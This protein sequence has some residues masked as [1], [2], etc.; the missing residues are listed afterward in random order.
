MIRKISLLL[1]IFI[2]SLK[3]FAQYTFV[4][5]GTCGVPA[6]ACTNVCA[7][8]V[9]KI[10]NIKSSTA[11]YS[12]VLFSSSTST[13]FLPYSSVNL[14]G[15]STSITT[16]D[17]YTS[18]VTLPFRF[19]FYDDASSPYNK[20]V[21]SSNGIISFDITNAGLFSHYQMLKDTAGNFRTA[22]PGTGV[23]PMDL[24]DSLY[25][26]S[27]IMGPYH[28]LDMGVTTSANRKIKYDVV[29]VAPYRKFVLSFYQ[30]PLF[31]CNP[32][33]QN[34]HQIVLYEGTGIIEVFVYSNQYCTGATAWNDGRTMI[35]LQNYRRNKA[36]MPA[37]RKASSPQWGTAGMNETWRFVPSSGVPL[38]DSVSLYDT[39]GHFV[40]VGDTVD[41]GNGTYDVNF[42][43]I[44]PNLTGVTRFIIKTK[45]RDILNPGQ[46]IYGID[47]LRV[48]LDSGVMPSRPK[49]AATD[50]ILTFCQYSTAV[51]L[52]AT[53]VPVNNNMSL[54]WYTD[55]LSGIF[56]NTAPT[57]STNTIG[58]TTYF[59]SNYNRCLESYRVPIIVNV[60]PSP[61]APV[62]FTNATRCG[63]GTLTISVTPNN[64]G[65]T[66]DWY[67]S[68]TGG[69]KLRTG[70]ATFTTPSIS[71]T[72]TYYAETRNPITNCVS[73]TRTAVI[74]FITPKPT[75]AAITQAVCSGSSFTITPVNGVPATN[76][77]PVGTTYTWTVGTNTNLSGQAAQA[78]A[79]SNIFGTI[80]SSSSS[81]QSITYT[82]T[83]SN[84]TCVGTAFSTTITVT[85]LPIL[86]NT[87]KTICT[88]NTTNFTLTSNVSSTYSWVA[89]DNPNTT[90][91]SLTQQTGSSINN[92][93]LNASTTSQAVL[94]TVTPTSVTG[95]CAG[96][97]QVVT[98]NVDPSPT[99][100]LRSDTTVCLGSSNN[101]FK[102][103]A[104]SS[105]S[106][107]LTTKNFSNTGSY[108]IPDNSTVGVND[109][110]NVSGLVNSATIIDSIKFS[111]THTR[112]GDIGFTSNP[113]AITLKAPDGTIYNSGLTPLTTAG[114]F[115]IPSS[116]YSSY[117]GSVNGAWTLNVKD[118]RAASTGSIT[119][120]TIW[121]KQYNIS[122]SPLT[123]IS[124]YYTDTPTVCPT[125]NV[126]YTMTAISPIGCVA[127]SSIAI[128]NNAPSSAR[129]TYAGAPYCHTISTNQSAT[130]NGT[131]TFTGGTYSA[132]PS[133]LS[134]NP[135]TGDINPNTSI[136]NTY[137]V[138]Y[139]IPGV[140]CA[141]VH[142][143]TTVVI[144]NNPTATF[145]YPGSPYCSTVSTDQ[146]IN[147]TGTSGGTFS[148]LSSGL[149]I[150]STTG[151]INPSL[152]TPNTYT[153]R[154]HLP[155]LSGCGAYDKDTTLVI[156]SAPS[157]AISYTGSPFCSNLPIPQSVNLTGTN[158]YLFG[159]FTADSIGLHID[160]TTGTFRADSSVARTYV[161]KYT[162]PASGGCG[163]DSAKTTIVITK[164][165]TATINYIGT[166]YCTSIVTSQ[167]VALT[168]T[169]AFNGGFFISSPAGLNLN[170]TNGSI[171]PGHSDSGY[172]TVTYIIPASAGCGVDSAKTNIVI[173]KAPSANIL[174]PSTPYCSSL[175]TPQFVQ[176]NGLFAYL[177]GTFTSDV[178]GLHIDNSNGAVRADSSLAGTYIVK[179]TI[180]ASGGC[181]IDSA[182]TTI[183]ITKAPTANIDY[184]G[185][186][187]CTS[188]LT[189]QT[190]TFSNTSGAYTG[191]TFT[192][193][194][195]SNI[196]LNATTGAINP[197]LSD[198]GT[199][200]I[201]YNIPAF[202]GCNAEKAVDTI[203]ITKAP[204][205][206]I[207]YG[208]TPY[209]T[210]LASA[211]P[212]SI[213]GQFAFAGGV[214][215]S[216]PSGLT[217]N[218]S[219]GEIQ[220]NASLPGSYT[221]KYT[222]PASAGCSI[223][224]AKTTLTITKAPTANIQYAS[225]P[226][227]ISLTNPQSVFL[228][229][230]DA[231]SGGTYSSTP[232]GL[233][234]TPNTGSIIPVNSIAGSY[235]ITYHIP[236]S[237]GCNMDSTQTSVII[238]SLPIATAMPSFDS[239]CSAS[240]SHVQLSSNLNNT[241]YS[242]TSTNNGVNGGLSDSGNVIQQ[243]LTT[244]T[245]LLGVIT[246][247]ITPSANGCTGLPI[248]HDVV[249]KSKPEIGSNRSKSI[250]FG[251]SINLLNPPFINTNSY[252]NV[253][254]S[255]NGIDSLPNNVK[256]NTTYQ[257]E[258]TSIDGCKDTV[259]ISVKI[260]PPVNAKAGN[261]TIA[262]IGQDHQLK[263]TGGVY[264]SWTPTFPL[265]YQKDSVKSNPIVIL[266]QDQLFIVSV[267]N[268][269]G[270]HA[271][272]SIFVRVYPGP[273]YNTP[274]A[275]S[276]NG[277]GLNDVFKVVPAGIAYTEYFKIYNRSGQLIFQS[278]NW[279][280]G[281]DG[282]FNGKPQPPGTYVW[283]VKGVDKNGATIEKKGTLVLIK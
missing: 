162:I 242:W 72:T 178:A 10:P 167:P 186:P 231:Y 67:S 74:A 143:D 215:T 15:T 195:S 65:E 177:G 129:I 267:A 252:Q 69:T 255:V 200:F 80:S 158:A 188:L 54:R 273:D 11:S 5:G 131:G 204:S 206:S 51:P 103:H 88:G 49:I 279:M 261:D 160:S 196:T 34:T 269:I 151:A 262:I 118:S 223:D 168:G 180:P 156:T 212:V 63:T 176:L 21:V 164:A 265:K 199:Y 42:R 89:A 84:G 157:A 7:D 248:T 260:L 140:G 43:C 221:V 136:P 141:A 106:E 155:A 35:G 268:S 225:A 154:Y 256:A 185:A 243:Y 233:D 122:W 128:T 14:G 150:N 57:P 40:T 20:L 201:T 208:G 181:G 241:T 237:A 235:T 179:Y 19:P 83:P 100:V 44:N 149:S 115:T 275:F 47:T 124:N 91:E 277:D 111:I 41:V 121:V 152:S 133:G 191:G 250:C 264:Y 198:S 224:S 134:I 130:L 247:T 173:T 236:A 55:T 22:T 211:Q 144:L 172:Y 8:I 278:N 96:T 258:A 139:D 274:N 216:N 270:C 189:D 81:S 228:S 6:N 266:N 187:F 87:T 30:V 78:T 246:Y 37:N 58:T 245:P 148:S 214:F 114:T 205:A 175:N 36:T 93:L 132:T 28:D 64:A 226:F 263:A 17:I 73:G 240:Y 120:F 110:I 13:C 202:A 244:S 207:L 203:I 48:V 25:D 50:S 98:I 218:S 97:P 56:S 26:K 219:T 159:V 33:I 170:A 77:V 183:V 271:S 125:S 104:T 4:F 166:P 99:I 142:A 113:N 283:I 193:L 108:S 39:L 163:I 182:K 52:R 229:G 85:P 257:L 192:S 184:T 281:W 82:V 234:L 116:V 230:T 23:V 146:S 53:T 254:W 102:L 92:T 222:I 24:P 210:S 95:T 249:V 190:V 105:V 253:R 112:P 153:V 232:S 280:K 27:L 68:P 66:I 86:S 1:L 123:N 94:Y 60:I 2:G 220:A 276:P 171:D 75:I 32:Q 70:S 282:S 227:C 29:G 45:Y 101:C 12:P 127:S 209:C 9:A 135:T 31:S 109:I 38:L 76:V 238:K 217:I 61:N 147:F 107:G 145:E 46:F 59:V 62:V 161:V 71:V 239:I 79:Q 213:N 194:P 137:I 16:D 165:P 169:D 259:L 197:S 272:D 138:S 251:D 119:N 126:T 174:Y 18:A 117:T 3:S 90:G